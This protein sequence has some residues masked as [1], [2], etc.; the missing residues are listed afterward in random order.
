M[1]NRFYAFRLEL[2]AMETVTKETSRFGR[3][4][5][6]AEPGGMAR[7]FGQRLKAANASRYGEMELE[8]SK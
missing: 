7:V 5:S 6:H 4:V 3:I 2:M 1:K 8:T